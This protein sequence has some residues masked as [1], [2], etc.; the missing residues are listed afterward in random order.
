[1]VE[2]MGLFEKPIE[3]MT[4]D[5]ARAAY[6]HLVRNMGWDQI[7]A[8]EQD[9]EPRAGDDKFVEVRKRAIRRIREL[10]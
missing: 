3:E 5:E 2:H 6:D 4:L 10:E 1:M 8:L 7:H 9:P